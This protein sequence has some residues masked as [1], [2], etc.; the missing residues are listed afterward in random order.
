MKGEMR[1]GPPKPEQ[2][3]EG[4]PT[5]R[6]SRHRCLEGRR[7]GCWLER[8]A[9]HHVEEVGA[10]TEYL[11]GNPGE[12]GPLKGTDVGTGSPGSFLSR[13]GSR[14]NTGVTSPGR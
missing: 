10:D 6:G 1:A 9:Q 12:S 8:P 14:A 2:R 5:G 13:R 4:A 7:P 11:Q 3:G